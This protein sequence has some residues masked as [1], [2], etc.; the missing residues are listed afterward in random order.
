MPHLF[1]N[2]YIQPQVF[3]ITE[4]M[5]LNL[6]IQGKGL[7]VLCLHGHPGSAAC[8]SV[9]TQ[10]LSSRFQTLAPD[11]RGYGN[12]PASE[13]F[14]MVEH[15]HDLEML[16]E[17]YEID[18]CLIVGW[19]LGG[20]LAMELAL[21]FPERVQ[22]LVLI[23]TAARPW[24]DHPPI[25]WTDYVYTG[26]ASIL[27]RL[28]PGWV[29]N[30]DTFGKRSLYRYL[31]QQHTPT[32]YQHLADEGMMAFLQ[33]SGVADRALRQALSTRYNR[34]ADLPQI[35]CPVLVLAGEADRHITAQSSLE[36]AQA[37]PHCEWHIYPNAAHLLPWEIPTQLLADIDRWIDQ[38]GFAEITDQATNNL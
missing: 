12:S 34:L 35:Q 23:A 10:H 27:N 11:L 5:I 25:A 38:H 33:T 30:I 26:L 28:Y 20:I 37:L 4:F 9:F 16:L 32:A 18:R 6:N 15:L 22:G 36:T 8:M 19:S 14:T 7:P 13:D 3:K 17:R 31:L 21:K 24:G 1:K 2:F 29:W